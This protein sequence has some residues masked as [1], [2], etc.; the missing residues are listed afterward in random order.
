MCINK[1]LPNMQQP[2]MQ[3]AKQEAS[4][5]CLC[6][7][8][9]HKYKYYKQEIQPVKQQSQPGSLSNASVL[10]KSQKSRYGKSFANKYPNQIHCA[11]L[12]SSNQIFV[13]KTSSVCTKELARTTSADLS[14]LFKR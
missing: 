10:S 13:K 4:A 2:N 3:R 7:Q 9:Y 12:N 5:S 11:N 1:T 14:I 8:Q 6:H